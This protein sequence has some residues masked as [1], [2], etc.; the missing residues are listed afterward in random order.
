VRSGAWPRQTRATR[1]TA[2]VRAA[3]GW[4][5][6]G[7]V[8]FQ[9]VAG[10]HGDGA[11]RC[12]AGRAV[13]GHMRRV[14]GPGRRRRAVLY[15]RVA[16]PEYPLWSDT[17]VTSRWFAAPAKL[18]RVGG[19]GPYCWLVAA[20]QTH[21]DRQSIC[22]AIP[23]DWQGALLPARRRSGFPGGPACHTRAVV[24]RVTASP[25]RKRARTAAALVRLGKLT[26][27]PGRDHRPVLQ[28]R[29]ATRCMPSM[30]RLPGPRIT[31]S[32]RSASATRRKCPVT[33][34]TSG[35]SSS[36]N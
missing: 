30:T 22:T 36:S 1:R 28:Q 5:I 34:R 6:L 23:G 24:P 7:A 14:R 27:P 19:G 31:G 29:R 35:R 11:E 15:P 16:L 2:S 33:F 21:D 20:G 26:E 9:D 25:V 10:L 4:L 3:T 13:H 8:R 18:L 12:P 32:D 17:A